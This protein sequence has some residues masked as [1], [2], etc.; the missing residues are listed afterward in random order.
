MVVGEYSRLTFDL[1]KYQTTFGI[2][3]GISFFFAVKAIM[4]SEHPVREEGRT[5]K[6]EI[7]MQLSILIWQQFSTK[8]MEL[9]CC[10]KESKKLCPEQSKDKSAC[11]ST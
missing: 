4:D 1:N 11:G 3:S 5:W 10:N 7:R 8:W 2:N 6:E 9:F